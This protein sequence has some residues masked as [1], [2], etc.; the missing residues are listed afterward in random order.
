MGFDRTDN[1]L[2]QYEDR[3]STRIIGTENLYSHIAADT[4]LHQPFDHTET[5]LSSAKGDVSSRICGSQNLHAEIARQ[6]Q[7]RGPSSELDILH[8]KLKHHGRMVSDI[9]DTAARPPGVIV[10]SVHAS[11][12]QLAHA[13]RKL[14][15]KVVGS[16]DYH[17]HMDFVNHE[18]RFQQSHQR[19]GVVAS[20]DFYNICDESTPPAPGSPQ[21][22][23]QANYTSNTATYCD[24]VV[25]PYSY[26]SQHIMTGAD[27]SAPPVGYCLDGRVSGRRHFMKGALQP[28]PQPLVAGGRESETASRHYYPPIVDA[29]P[30]L[31]SAQTQAQY[32]IPQMYVPRG[33]QQTQ[34][35]TGHERGELSRTHTLRIAPTPPIYTSGGETARL[36]KQRND[37][38]RSICAAGMQMA[39]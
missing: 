23:Q 14:I 21:A 34:T 11:E 19:R 8:N 5:D 6:K 1:N 17:S 13:G 35:Q 36:F 26:C 31:G 22:Q 29:V 20:G 15:A 30:V 18:R 37:S 24:P 4:R 16:N 39:R 9:T 2:K 3:S 27:R 33:F 28:Q 7:R 32:S 10:S 12:N 38:Y 25:D